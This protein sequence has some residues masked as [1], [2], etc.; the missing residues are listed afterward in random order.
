MSLFKSVLALLAAVS[1]S[2]GSA[3]ESVRRD[4]SAEEYHIEANA[5]PE[6]LYF[7]LVRLHSAG[8]LAPERMDAVLR[9]LDDV[10]SRHEEGSEAHHEQHRVALASSLRR[11]LRE[12]RQGEDSAVAEAQYSGR[13]YARKL[14]R[15][16]VR[17]AERYAENTLVI[18][19]MMGVPTGK[20]DLVLMVAIPVGGYVVVKMGG[21]AL[22]RAA[23]LMRKLRSVDDVV[24]RRRT[25]GIPPTAMTTARH[26]LK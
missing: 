23:F 10:D 1:I 14:N 7:E 6:E 25:L 18:A 24:D 21:M 16:G 22:K 26:V 11:A 8:L 2:C 12:L 5:S 20:E 3:D 19:G 4:G 9:A 17:E 13:A 15:T